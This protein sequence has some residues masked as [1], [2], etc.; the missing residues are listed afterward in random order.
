MR[1]SKLKPRKTT[2]IQRQKSHKAPTYNTC[3][4]CGFNTNNFIS[5]W[6][7]LFD[8]GGDKT[9]H[10]F[11]QTIIKRY[12]QR[13]PSTH[14]PLKVLFFCNHKCVLEFIARHQL[15]ILEEITK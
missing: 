1:R 8:A 14:I 5:D 9:H 4:N 12:G 7:D 13:H 6:D 3:V 15:D 10:P 11:E 2:F